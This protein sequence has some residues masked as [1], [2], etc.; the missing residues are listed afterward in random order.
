MEL[1]FLFQRVQL[2]DNHKVKEKY[3]RN[4]VYSL[5]IINIWTLYCLFSSYE[6]QVF[7][8]FML[9]K[10]FL[11]SVAAAVF[12]GTSI[13]VLRLIL[14]KLVR[15]QNILKSNFVYSFLGVLNLWLFAIWLIVIFMRVNTFGFFDS[16]EILIFTSPLLISTFIFTDLYIYRLVYF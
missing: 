5:I 15:F 9:Q 12:F 8:G 13:I 7:Y 3:L 2:L 16:F 1:N 14:Y 10:Y 4:L 11:K 6:K